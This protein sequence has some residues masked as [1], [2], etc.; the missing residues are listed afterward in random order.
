VAARPWTATGRAFFRSAARYA[1]GARWRCCQQGRSPGR[2]A[3]GEIAVFLAAA[4]EIDVLLIGMGPE[5]AP[6]IATCVRGWRAPGS[7][8]EI[9]ARRRP[10][11][12]TTCSW[13][14]AGG[15]QLIAV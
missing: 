1:I 11:G 6:W 2:D 10:A 3:A 13:P 9:M 12:P 8:A 7:G 5:I 4:D 15:S 14:R